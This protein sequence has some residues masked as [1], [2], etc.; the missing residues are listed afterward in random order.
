MKNFYFTKLK[1]ITTVVALFISVGLFAQSTITWTGANS[2]DYSDP[3]NWE[4]QGNIDGNDVVIGHADS[5]TFPCIIE[6]DV[7]VTVN[8]L[9][10]SDATEEILNP[11]TPEA[12]TVMHAPGEITINMATGTWFTENFNG[13]SKYMRGIRNIIGGNYVY[14]RN[15]NLY[16]DNP[17]TRYNVDCDTFRLRGYPLFGKKNNPLMCVTMTLSGNTLAL[18]DNSSYSGIDRFPSGTS[19]AVTGRPSLIFEDEAEMI[20]NADAA[21]YLQ[22]PLDSGL[23]ATTPDRDLVVYFDV[24]L[25]KT[26]VFTRLKT[27]FVIEPMDRQLLIAGEAGSMVYGIDNDG[28]KS[29]ESLEWKYGTTSGGP[30]DMSFDPAETNDTI[31]PVFPTSG[32]FYLALEGTKGGETFYTNEVNVNVASNKAK[33][34]PDLLQTIRLGQEGTMLTVIEEGTSTGREWK[35]ATTPG[36]P[37]DSFDPAI[38]GTEFTPDFTEVGT[39]YVVCMSDIDGSTATTKEVQFDIIAEDAGAM[40]LVFTGAVE[41]DP[42]EAGVMFNWDPAAHIDRNNLAIPDGMT[43]ELTKEGTVTIYKLDIGRDA[44]FSLNN[45]DSLIYDEDHNTSAGSFLV[46]N[47]IFLK[48]GGYFRLYDQT[49]TFT[50]KN[51]SQVIMDGAGAVLLGGSNNPATGSNVFIQDNA[52]MYFNSAGVGRISANAGHS[53]MH[54]QDNAKYIFEGDARGSLSTYLR[55]QVTTSTLTDINGND[56]IVVDTTFH[57]KFVVPDGFEPYL[58][59]DPV[60]DVTTISARDL[61]ALAIEQTSTQIVGMGQSTPALSLINSSA[62]TSFE[63]VYSVSAAGPWESFDPAKTGE[64]ATFA[65]DTAGVVFVKCIADGSVETSNAIAI[66]TISVSVEPAGTQSIEPNAN[67]TQLDVMLPEGVSGTEWKFTTTSGSGY[68]GFFPI[69]QTDTFYV[70]NFFDM[71]TYYVVFEAV[72][73]DDNGQDVV[74]YSNEVQINVGDVA[75][76]KVSL[77]EAS[78]YPNP[79]KESFYVDGGSLKAYELQVIDLGGAVVYSDSFNQVDGPQ[80]VNFNKTGFYFVKL[81]SDSGI[82]VGRLVIE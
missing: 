5:Y 53:E 72:A 15:K 80:R 20:I 38:T 31:Y 51:N 26:F 21:G 57:Q 43:A 82:K 55:P 56:S 37:Y 81:V 13:D 54:L 52:T 45:N 9:A 27:A 79:A 41:E 44:V 12:D 71:G 39:Y 61:S 59:Y 6:S 69:A 1:M 67:G 25:A 24:A 64:T 47:G 34:T 76:N 73:T 42:N 40:N 70:P 16:M 46:E 36:G 33:V 32:D 50:V 35:V 23:L 2:S 19:V 65:F 30:Y 49:T 29:M 11:D 68:E 58:V 18:F 48:K 4:P 74:V 8:S 28:L 62:Y 77:G 75:I 78:I 7:D 3:T 17:N 60:E 63:W 66:N 14:N 22:T 10:V